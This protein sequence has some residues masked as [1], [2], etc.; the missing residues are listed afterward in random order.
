MAPQKVRK[1]VIPVAGLGTR[2]LPITKAIPKEMLPIVDRPVIEMIVDEAL[3]SGIEEIIL[4][5][6]PEKKSIEN[7]FAPNI[8]LNQV[9]ADRNKTDSLNQL[10]KIDVKANIHPVI[11]EEALGLGHAVL[12]AKDAVGDEPFAVMLGDDVIRTKLPQK[13]AI[14]QLIEGYESTNISQVSL[15]RVPRNQVYLYGAAECSKS[16]FGK[17]ILEVD[18]LVEKPPTGTEKTDLAVIGRYVLTSD[19]WQ[20]LER[21]APGA[22]GEIQI[23]DALDK[24]KDAAG[25]MGYLFDG[26]RIDAGERLGYLKLILSEALEREDIGDGVR[27][28]LRSM[29]PTLS[30]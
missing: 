23:T 26:E 27:A 25:L 30:N 12:C 11:Q 24:L 7:F 5:T 10:K 9:L 21:Q 17:N 20:L 29:D 3:A 28:L 1:A 15:M 19:I 8:E 16:N 13:P 14:Q 6:S 2:F 18:K 22:G 4:V